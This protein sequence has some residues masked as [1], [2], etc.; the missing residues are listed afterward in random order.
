MHSLDVEIRFL[1]CFAI[2]N[3]STYSRMKSVLTGRRKGSASS[4]PSGCTATAWNH[5]RG[6]TT[7][8]V[9]VVQLF[10]SN[11]EYKLTWPHSTPK[12]NYRRLALQQHNATSSFSLHDHHHW[13]VDRSSS[14]WRTISRDTKPHGLPV[15]PCH[16]TYRH[17]RARGHTH[18]CTHI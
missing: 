2:Q 16:Y 15:C 12:S 3:V 17:T 14:D 13:L 1:L 9:S 10:S 5:A 11:T 18:T 6:V 8:T 7:P 4:T